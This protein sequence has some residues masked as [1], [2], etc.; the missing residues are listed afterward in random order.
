MNF[1]FLSFPSIAVIVEASTAETAL[2]S[3]KPM[4][5]DKQPLDVCA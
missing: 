3:M 4:S 5:M 1:S 2:K